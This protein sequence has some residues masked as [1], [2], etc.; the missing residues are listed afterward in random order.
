VNAYEIQLPPGIVISPIFD[1]A[2]LFP[3]TANPEEEDRTTWPTQN[4]Q[5]G[6][7]TWMR[8]MP[9]V[10]PPEI[11]SIL[12]T[13]VAKRTWW[14]EYLQYLVKWKNRPIED[15]LWLDAR[16][17]EQAGSSV[18]KLMDQSHDFFLPREPDVGA[19]KMEVVLTNCF[20]FMLVCQSR[21]EYFVYFQFQY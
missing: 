13:Q 2:D 6:G 16:Q 14:K 18:K 20:F 4:T 5:D 19:S 21:V 10:Q 12:D 7:E 8:Q 9:Y 3:Y 17:I 11:K 15:S 1:V